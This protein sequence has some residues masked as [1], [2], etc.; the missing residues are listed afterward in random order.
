M[1]LSTRLAAGAAIAAV[2]VVPATA[3]AKPVTQSDVKKQ[4]VVADKS[5]DKVVSLVKRNRD[6]ASIVH[7]RTYKRAVKKASAQTRSLR[8]NAT[9]SPRDAKAYAGAVKKLGL[10][11]DDCADALSKIV[12]DASGQAQ[13]DIAEQLKACIVTREKLIEQLTLLLDKV[14]EQVKPLVAK[15]IALLST[16]GGDDAGQI[17]DQL[18]NVNLPTGVADLLKDALEL[19]TGTIDDA[20]ERLQGILEMVPESVR[21]MVAQA[22]ALVNQQ[23]DQIQEMVSALLGNLLGGLPAAPGDGGGDTGGDGG[24]G[25]LFDGLP[26]FD[27]LQGLFGEGFPGNLIPIDLPFS[28]P[29]FGFF[30][31]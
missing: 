3:Q 11:S 23:I 14:P 7:L 19:A 25:G 8:R 1:K 18:G 27:L 13:V 6:G 9:D 28:I 4:V 22:L 12:D 31:R 10:M 21:P 5:L 24:L 20:Q 2:A 26:F 29:G 16:Q 15:V 30:T 17:T